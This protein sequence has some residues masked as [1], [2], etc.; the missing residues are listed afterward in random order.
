MVDWQEI[1]P[2][3]REL[4]ICN[5][6]QIIQNAKQNKINEKIQRTKRHGG[7]KKNI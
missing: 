1:K 3:K 2:I 7:Y 6:K 5:I 4:T